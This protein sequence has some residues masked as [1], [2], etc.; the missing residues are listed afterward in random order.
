MTNTR[1]L[2]SVIG[3]SLAAVAAIVLVAP[4]MA[5]AVPVVFFGENLNPGGAVSGA[6]LT[7]HDA[8]LASLIGVGTETFEGQAGQ[9]APLNLTFPGSSGNITATLAGQGGVCDTASTVVGGIGC[10]GFGRFPTSGNS[11]FHTTA[12]GFSVSFSS[13]ISAFGFYGTD[14]GDFSGQ[15]TATTAGG[16]IVNFVVPHTVDAPNGSLVFWGFIDADTSYTS[17]TFG[18]SNGTDVFGFDDLIIGD[19]KQVVPTPEPMTL[20]LLGLGLVAIAGLRSWRN[21]A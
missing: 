19:Q 15:L 8:F 17:I 4:S 1:K 7:A 11:W 18:A 2:L 14:I 6:P 21:R 13:A 16:D 5:F 9:E 3:K 20:S 12:P 10:N